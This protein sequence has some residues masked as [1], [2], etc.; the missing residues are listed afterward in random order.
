MHHVLYKCTCV[1]VKRAH[2]MCNGRRKQDHYVKVVSLYQ[3]SHPPTST[4]T[5]ARTHTQPVYTIALQYGFSNESIIRNCII[6][7]YE[8]SKIL[9]YSCTVCVFQNYNVLLSLNITNWNIQCVLK[10][11]CGTFIVLII[12]TYYMAYDDG[13]LLFYVFLGVQKL[14]IFF[15]SLKKKWRF[16]HLSRY[17][18]DGFLTFRQREVLLLIML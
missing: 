12:N 7:F 9:K 2:E 17:T 8:I 3:P 18:N 4:H 13:C 15:C 1:C 10:G 6:R 5:R 11:N 14:L 16:L